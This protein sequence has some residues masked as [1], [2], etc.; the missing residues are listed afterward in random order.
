MTKQILV[1]G[2]PIGG[3]APVSVQSMTNTDTRDV[4]ATVAQIE[5]LTEAGCNIVRSSVYDLKCAKALREIKSR[6][7][8]PIVADIHFDYRLA[9]TAMENGADKLRFNPGNIGD[10]SRVKAVV[11]C[12]KTHHTPIRI[13]VNAGSIEP[14]LRQKYGG[15]TTEA[16]IESALKHVVILEREG[17]TDIV[18]SLKASNVRDTVDAYRAVS[19]RVDYPLHVGVTETGDVASGIIKSAAGIGALLLDGIGDTIRVSL[20]DDPVHEVETGLKIL[21]AVGLLRDDIELVSCPTCGRTRVDVMKMVEAVNTRLPHKKGYLKIAVMGCAVNG[22]GEARD[23]D[24][25]VAFGDGNGILFEKGQQV[26]HGAA[27]EVIE[28][29]IE[30]ANEMLLMQQK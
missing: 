10:E 3:G 24:I 12:A 19:K 22:P 14:A 4:E 20:T 9:I 29:L 18:L 7:R 23:A 25:G 5:R 15:P 21:R 16:M 8:I 17:F 6:I 1:G 11:D 28:R 26:Y 27:D 13:G 30:R 2:I